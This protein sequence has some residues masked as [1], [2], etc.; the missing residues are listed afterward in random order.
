MTDSSRVQ[1][2]LICV[3]C[4]ALGLIFGIGLL[5]G[6]FW[7]VAIPVAVLLA[8][9]LGLAFW[10]GFTIATIQVEPE[11]SPDEPAAGA[12]ASRDRPS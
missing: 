3:V 12:P 10:V 9:A 1:G 2:A 11:P 4:V 7:A 6:A 5:R 8:F